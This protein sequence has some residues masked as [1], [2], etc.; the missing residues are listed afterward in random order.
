MGCG[1]CV[2]VKGLVVVD[3]LSDTG[4]L[5]LLGICRVCVL[6]AVPVAGVAGVVHG[7]VPAVLPLGCSGL[8]SRWYVHSATLTGYRACRWYP[9]ALPPR[10][11]SLERQLLLLMVSV[12]CFALVSHGRL[13]DGAVV[14]CWVS[15]AVPAVW[16][17]ERQLPRAFN[18]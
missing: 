7:I 3:W 9:P 12:F 17:S 8:S 15:V 13:V 16:P 5:I 6:F 1:L 11:H 4:G 14:S 10:R 18:R 2:L